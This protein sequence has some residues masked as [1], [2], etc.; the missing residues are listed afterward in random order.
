MRALGHPVRYNEN[1]HD[2]VALITKVRD[3]D[4]GVVDLAVFTDHACVIRQSITPGDGS[5]RW[6]R[7]IDFHEYSAELVEGAPLLEGV[8]RELTVLRE[9]FATLTA[10]LAELAGKEVNFTVQKIEVN[11]DDPDRFVKGLVDK[12]ESSKDSDA[13]LVPP[14]GV[15]PPK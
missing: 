11:G 1:G 12:F 2:Y 5:G 15:E 9:Q 8:E 3:E 14:G 10:Q 6:S 7:L 13:P 4:R